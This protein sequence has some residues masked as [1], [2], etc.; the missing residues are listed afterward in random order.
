M[1]VGAADMLWAPPTCSGVHAVY[2]FCNTSISDSER[3]EDLLGRLTL[4]EQIGM[5]FMQA[6]MAYGNDT[7]INGTNGDLPSTNVSRLGINEFNWMGQGSLYRGASNGCDVNCCS[8]G[9]PPCMI[10][11]PFATVFPQGTGWA[12]MFNPRLA[13]AAGRVIA[14]ESRALQSVPNRTGE[15]YAKS[16]HRT[17]HAALECKR[18]RKRKCTCT[19]GERGMYSRKIDPHA[20]VCRGSRLSYMYMYMYMYMYRSHVPRVVLFH[21]NK[22]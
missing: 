12:A 2:P 21:S 9:K 7:I 3:V 1:L 6:H 11:R 16:G 17:G 22:R 19:R 8:G 20:R 5:L 13:F 4:Q 15:P 14:N 18:K 10:D